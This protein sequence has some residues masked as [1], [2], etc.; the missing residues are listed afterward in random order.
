M[1]TLDQA[2]ISA[3]AEILGEPGSAPPDFDPMPARRP[4][5]KWF[6]AGGLVVVLGGLA[7]SALTMFGGGLS[8]RSPG[9][10]TT[11]TVNRGDLLVTVTEDGSL[12]SAENLDIKCEVAGGTTIVWII[13]DGKEVSKGT[14]LLRLDASK[15]S[16]DVSQQKIAFEKARAASIQT[17]QD[18]AA[19][20]IAVEEYTEGTFKKEFREAESKVA[21]ARGSLQSAENSLQHGQ[22]M[23][24]KGYISPLQLESQKTALEHAKLDLGT[25]EIAM[26]VL[27]HFTRPKMLQ[28]LVAAGAGPIGIGVWVAA[29]GWIG[30]TG[31]STATK[32]E[33]MIWSC[34]G[35]RN[36]K[37]R[38]QR[39]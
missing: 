9:P 26:D 13:D 1:G 22:R 37:P 4:L 7:L 3:V 19:A 33:R 8:P 36:K 32:R 16:E 35:M 24:R 17:A 18:F 30:T 11:Y 21:V 5:R 29:T 12:E 23:F 39:V 31:V 2:D 38:S 10:Q 15:L 34:R 27:R 28:E 20:K 14:E 6:I 25:A